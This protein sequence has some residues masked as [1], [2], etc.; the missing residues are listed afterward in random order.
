MNREN[1]KPPDPKERL[2]STQ[3][4]VV[5]EKKVYG[6]PKE[7]EADKRDYGGTERRAEE[8]RTNKEI[9]ME[10]DETPGCVEG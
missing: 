6:K 9:P 2:F 1:K 5:G 8:Q 7:N 10:E 4:K 3:W